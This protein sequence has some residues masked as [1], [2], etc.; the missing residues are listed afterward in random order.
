[1]QFAESTTPTIRFTNEY[2]NYIQLSTSDKSLTAV[3][4]NGNNPLA[5]LPRNYRSYDIRYEVDAII[6]AADADA[7]TTWTSTREIKIYRGQS[8]YAGK[9]FSRRYIELKDILH[10]VKFSAPRRLC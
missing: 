8:P 10:F 1:M 2:G 4:K 5:E 6:T 7:L 9:L 3:F